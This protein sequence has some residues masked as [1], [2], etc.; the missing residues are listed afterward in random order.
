MK[1][2]SRDQSLISTR[3]SLLCLYLNA[4]SLMS[5]E[6]EFETT[7]EDCKPD[8]IGAT[9]SWAYSNTFDEELELSDYLMYRQD[10]PKHNHGGG[11][12]LY[13]KKNLQSA[14][15]SCSS[16]L[17]TSRFLTCD[18][19]L[20]FSS[21]D[22]SRPVLSCSFQVAILFF[23]HDVINHLLSFTSSSSLPFDSALHN[24]VKHAV[25]L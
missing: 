21:T 3:G 24:S 6:E 17:S 23:C 22:L 20:L 12:L 19:C 15:F 1:V 14:A 13:V 16:L 5:K 11:V 9:E 18:I 25:M 10:H 8:I 7:V 2:T 4:R